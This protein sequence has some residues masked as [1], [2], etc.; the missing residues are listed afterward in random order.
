MVRLL[1]GCDDALESLM[2]RHA[3]RL[4]SQLGR[5]LRCSV[6]A[7]ECV[8]EAFVRVYQ[9]RKDFHL[10]AKF[11]TWLYTIAFNL[12]RD[13]LRR[14]ARRPEF[15]SWEAPDKQAVGDLEEILLDPNRPPDEAMVSEERSRWLAEAV[16]SLPDTLRQPL[17]LYTE[18]DKSQPEIAA[19]MQCTVKAV[20]MR[21]YHAH[22]RLH[23]LLKKEFKEFE[24][25]CFL[26]RSSS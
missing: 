11:S 7:R 10:G 16:A 15:V 26:K 8:Q 1:A 25:F 18:E 2:Q 4:L 23:S 22:K 14:Q 17:A 19:E 12:A 6:D 9:H 3:K 21:L 13:R 24:G 5:V 20:E